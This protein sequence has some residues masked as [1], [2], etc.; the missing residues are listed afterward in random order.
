M[1]NSVAKLLERNAEK[2]GCRVALADEFGE[3]TW[4]EY[5]DAAIKIADYL[6]KEVTK[7]GFKKPVGILIDRNRLSIIAFLGCACSGNF[8]IPLD[9]SMPAERLD[10]ILKELQPVCLLD[11]RGTDTVYDGAV[12]VRTILKEWQANEEAVKNAVCMTIDTDPLYA[13]F[14]SGSTGIPKGVLVSHRSVL[15]LTEAFAEAFQFDETSV[16]GNQAPYDFDVSV[17]DIYNAL[18]CAGRVE[19]I[20]KRMFVRPNLLIPYLAERGINTLIWAVSAVRI[21]ADFDTFHEVK[22]EKPLMLRYVMFSGEVMPVKALNYWMDFLPDAI[23]VNLYG[24]TEI[25]CNCTYFLVDKRYDVDQVLPVGKP[26]SN[27]RVLLLDESNRNIDEPHVT[28]EICVEGTGV[29]LGYWNNPEKTRECFTRT[30]GT[31]EYDSRMYRTGDLG[32]YD[33]DGNIC[34]ASRK[35]HQIKHMGHRI[36]LGEIETVINSLT[37]IDVCCCLYDADKEKIVCFYQAEQENKKAIVSELL[38]R[39]PKYMWPGKYVCME[40]LPLNR[41]GKIDRQELAGRLKDI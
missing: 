6:I 40:K 2:S 25:T 9:A 38:K 35:D 24:P 26:F 33:A 7:G 3:T 31:T 17:K 11:A 4:Q 15:D 1:L 21:V 28:G 14:T 19:V 22:T 41:H 37:F 27:T 16:F 39:L 32:Y 30:P 18:Y 34:F 12:D 36:E 13:I 23:F 29:A 8:Y 5:R 20:P 10:L